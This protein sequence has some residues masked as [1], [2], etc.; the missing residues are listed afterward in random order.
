MG[1][2]G[3]SWPRQAWG[4]VTCQGSRGRVCWP[5]LSLR[6]AE[7]Q[8]GRKFRIQQGTGWQGAGAH[9]R[10]QHAGTVQGPA[11]N[12]RLCPQ[13][14]GPAPGLFIPP[15]T[16]PPPQLS[17]THPSDAA[18]SRGGP[19]SKASVPAGQDA[20][21]WPTVAPTPGSLLPGWRGH[22]TGRL[23]VRNP[24]G[25]DPRN[26]ALPPAPSNR[27]RMQQRSLGWAL[28]GRQHLLSASTAVVSEGSLGWPARE[29]AALGHVR[30]RAHGQAALCT[31]TLR[32][33]TGADLREVS[34]LHPHRDARLS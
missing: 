27:G 21:L 9:D 5:R 12:P 13:G 20:H 1:G 25:P 17:Y 34:L 11:G 23:R 16:L 30:N 22:T 24:W 10:S 33:H 14:A 8:E 19:R 3:S 28:A 15:P 29:G 32:T 26:T 2:G 31:E 4:L 6:S 18:R 7:H